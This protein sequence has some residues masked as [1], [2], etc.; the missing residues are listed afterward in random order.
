[1]YLTGYNVGSHR[2]NCIRVT[3][4]NSKG[5]GLDTVGE[6]QSWL[7]VGLM[8]SEPLVATARATGGFKFWY[9]TLTVILNSGL[10]Q[11]TTSHL[12]G[13]EDIQWNSL[14]SVTSD[15]IHLMQTL[16]LAD[17]DLDSSGLWTVIYWDHARRRWFP[18]L[19]SWMYLRSN[20]FELC[21]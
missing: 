9:C 17:V 18:Q 15:Y 14:E 11:I 8:R 7:S 6:L 5:F 12:G 2:R 16:N 3:Q 10:I 13:F 4:E 19:R 1:M 21:T 20:S